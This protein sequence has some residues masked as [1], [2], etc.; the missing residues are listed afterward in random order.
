VKRAAATAALSLALLTS[1]CG[2]SAVDPGTTASP[3][4]TS[5]GSASAGT[6]VVSGERTYTGLVQDHVDGAVDYPQ[7]PPVGGAHSPVWMACDGRVYD[8]AL[9]AEKAVHSLEHG[10]VWVTWQPSLAPADVEA[11]DALVEGVN[12]RLGSPY[13]GLA[14]AITLTAWGHQMDADSVSDPRIQTFL[15]A[16]TNGPQTPEP[17]ATCDDPTG[18]SP[19][20]HSG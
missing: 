5:S 3:T 17:G 4:P 1:A 16:Y 9:P 2:A 8:S 19:D 15:D 18:A 20:V 14:A 6:T 13:P 11:L 10:A 12:Y 7:S